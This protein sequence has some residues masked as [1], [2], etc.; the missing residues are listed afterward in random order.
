MHYFGHLNCLH[1]DSNV[2]C[3]LNIFIDLLIATALHGLTILLD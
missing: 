1:T 2:M 3:C